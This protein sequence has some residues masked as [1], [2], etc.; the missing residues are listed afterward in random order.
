[1][2]TTTLSNDNVRLSLLPRITLEHYAAAITLLMQLALYHST[3]SGARAAAQVLLGTFNA[4]E[5]HLDITDLC[6]LDEDAL[7]AAWIVMRGRVELREEPHEC[8]ENGSTLFELLW[9]KF[10]HLR[11]DQRHAELYPGAT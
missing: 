3:T 10:I 5:F 8:I 1:M 2:T 9:V 11:N 4:Y 6:L 7:A